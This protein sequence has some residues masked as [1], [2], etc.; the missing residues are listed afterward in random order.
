MNTFILDLLSFGAV[1]SGIL[2]ITSKNPVISVLFLISVFV[3]AA[4]YLLV[5]GIG[6]IGISYLIVYV[7]AIAILF[8]FVVMM[9]NISLVE[10]ISVGQEY[11]KNLPLG[12]IVGALFIFEILSLVPASYKE[13]GE[14]PLGFVNYLNRLLLGVEGPSMNRVHMRFTQPGADQTFTNYLQI[15][16]IGE[17]LYTYG[18][19]WLFLASIILLLAMLGPIVLCLQPSKK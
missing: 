2:V 19:L 1:F 17:G 5:L 9:L 13:V 15:E 4:G 6:F 16:T 10:I 7:G 12:L 11:T 3:N 8:L 18:A 14:L